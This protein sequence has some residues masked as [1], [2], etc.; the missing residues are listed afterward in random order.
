M[1]YAS[2]AEEQKDVAMAKDTSHAHNTSFSPQ[3]AVPQGVALENRTVS[4]SQTVPL[5]NQAAAVSS[6][7]TSH[8]NEDKS[9][10]TKT[11]SS[12]LPIRSFGCNRNETPAIFVH[13]GK[14]GG[15]EVRARFAAAALAYNRTI[16][17]RPG[18]DDH[19]YPLPEG[20][21]AKFCN[22]AH[23]NHYPLP[24][25][26]FEGS[27]L[28]NATNPVSMAIACPDVLDRKCM[29]CTNFHEIQKFQIFSVITLFYF[30]Q[31]LNLIS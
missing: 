11:P 23:A 18:E 2:I 27:Q 28:C 21:K 4:R 6:P 1:W 17:H 25:G 15:G 10:T 13:L 30:S 14:A 9:T 8:N 5:A 20:Q 31:T 19:Y 3:K 7:P 29:G 16:W 24:I 12:T 26:S 22:S